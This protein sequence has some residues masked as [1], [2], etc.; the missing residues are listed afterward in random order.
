MSSGGFSELIEV[1]PAGNG[2]WLACGFGLALLAGTAVGMADLPGPI[3]PLAVLTAVAAATSGTW[4]RMYEPGRVHRAVLR[5]DAT[6]Q[7]FLV[8]GGPLEG[9]LLR[10]WG[11][12]TGVV[13]GL[14][15]YTE[16]GR[17]ISAWVLRRDMPEAA[18]RRLR[19][20]L[21]MA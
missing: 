11:R 17:R 20:R 16:S 2:A 1:R 7:L 9:R 6:W 3:G 13:V 15:W 5:P 21:R 4:Y 8:S 14:E 10:A 18:W 19:V 12:T